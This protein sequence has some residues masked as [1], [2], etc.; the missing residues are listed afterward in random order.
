MMMSSFNRY[1]NHLHDETTDSPLRL[2]PYSGPGPNT[3][4]TV[5]T[6]FPGKGAKGKNPANPGNFYKTKLRANLAWWRHPSN[7]CP[8]WLLQLLQHGVKVNF[9][10]KSTFKPPPHPP[11]FIDPCDT[12]FA[13]Q[14]L[15]DGRKIGDYTDLASGGQ[16]Y[17]VTRLLMKKSYRT[18]PSHFRCTLWYPVCGLRHLH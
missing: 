1:I 11:K 7:N 16:Q 12:L 18:S 14:V 15:Q 9:T 13:I 6:W 2:S 8:Q 4:P 10:D 17:L 3:R 5:P